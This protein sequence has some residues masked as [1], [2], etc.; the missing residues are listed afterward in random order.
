M[1][2]PNPRNT[3]ILKEQAEYNS[4]RRISFFSTLLSLCPTRPRTVSLIRRQRATPA[5]LSQ[6]QAPSA[7]GVDTIS[8]LTS[9]RT[10]T[11][12]PCSSVSSGGNPHTYGD[13]IGHHAGGRRL[14]CFVFIVCSLVPLRAGRGREADES[15]AIAGHGGLIWSS[16]FPH[17]SICQDFSLTLSCRLVAKQQVCVFLHVSINS[18]SPLPLSCQDARARDFASPC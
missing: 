12:S 17:F 4:G 2:N 15:E 13:Y 16:C 18:S 7:N 11:R 3:I 6:L 14:C 10:R 8:T 1:D 5:L 9:A